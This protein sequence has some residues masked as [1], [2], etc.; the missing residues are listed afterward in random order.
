M[1]DPNQLTF[2]VAYLAGLA[3]FFSP[4]LIPLLPSYFSIITGFTLKDLYGLNFKDLRLRVFF[5][6]LFFI[7]GFAVIY[8]LLG[9]T[10]SLLGQ[11]L[12]QHTNLLI[13]LSGLFLII[14][15]LI[16][17]SIIKFKG[18]EFDYAWLV[19]KKL[20]RLGF[21]NA[22]L[23]GVAMA[24]IWIP[25]VGQLVTGML[26]LASQTETTTQGISLLFTFSLGLGTPFLLLG[27][28]FPVIF[29][30]LQKNRPLLHLINLGAGG[31]LIIFG[32]VLATNQYFY[33]L[34]LLKSL[35]PI[36]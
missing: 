31:L 25:C 13:R 32:I 30:W 16:Q 12:N 17:L 9:A 19:Q 1:T 21:L 2:S 24:L 4:C 5:S 7:L 8:S 3:G 29:P 36:K 22:F 27:L 15:G 23:T 26:I 11:L 14:L 18:L 10:G 34:E 28:F 20:A 33:Y 6:S 35:F